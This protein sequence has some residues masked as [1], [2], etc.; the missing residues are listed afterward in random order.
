MDSFA[1]ELAGALALAQAQHGGGSVGAVSSTAAPA[2]LLP[3]APTGQQRPPPAPLPSQPQRTPPKA[4]SHA[5][6]QTE[7]SV[8]SV[9]RPGRATATKATPPASSAVAARPRWRSV[10]PFAPAG[11]AL[12]QLRRARQQQPQSPAL[13]ADTSAPVAAPVPAAVVEQGGTAAA[14]P[15]SGNDV[16]D[17]EQQPPPP[18]PP[19]SL[20]DLLAQ[21]EGGNEE[22]GQQTATEDAHTG[23]PGALPPAQEAEPAGAAGDVTAHDVSDDSLLHAPTAGADSTA[24]A[25]DAR[26][27]AARLLA[28]RLRELEA[29]LDAGDAAAARIGASAA[30]LAS[31]L[32]GGGHAAPVVRA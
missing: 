10:S 14:D 19:L 23:A 28:R 16:R 27:S 7:L 11:S 18:P 29:C 25:A 9:P 20:G 12:R 32:G 1:K 5:A 24:A 21:E 13:P 17:T 30:A 6:V 26:A 22:Q 4:S 31:R 3:A 15:A 8:G 2:T